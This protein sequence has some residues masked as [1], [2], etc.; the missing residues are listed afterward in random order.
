[1]T[2]GHASA[3]Q[4]G[5]KNVVR[6]PQESWHSDLRPVPL[7]AYDVEVIDDLGMVGQHDRL[8]VDV[9]REHRRRAIAVGPAE[10]GGQ[11]LHPATILGR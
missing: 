3:T 7:V 9:E 5:T 1:M 8:G 6:N 4:P 2:S 10:T 11:W